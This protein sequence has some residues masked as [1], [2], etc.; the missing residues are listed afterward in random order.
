MALMPNIKI[1]FG[2][3]FQDMDPPPAYELVEPVLQD[4][5]ERPRRY[6]ADRTGFVLALIPWIELLMHD[7]E[8]EALWNLGDR[9]PIYEELCEQLLG[10]RDEENSQAP[11]PVWSKAVVEYVVK[12]VVE[13]RDQLFGILPAW[14]ND[15]EPPADDW[16]LKLPS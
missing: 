16:G 2:D 6:G 10:G 7:Q 12:Y 13:R 4:M 3:D 11:D 5:A 15:G 9:D 8:D 14:Y 1:E